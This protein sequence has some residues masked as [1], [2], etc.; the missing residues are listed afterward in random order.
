M[1][2]KKI[3]FFHQNSPQLCTYV[4]SMKG[5]LYRACCV[6]GGRQFCSIC[7]LIS[8]PAL[9]LC[10]LSSVCQG[11][12]SAVVQVAAFTT[13]SSGGLALQGHPHHS[14]WPTAHRPA[15]CLHI[16]LAVVSSLRYF[17]YSSESQELKVLRE[18]GWTLGPCTVSE[19]SRGG[20]PEN[21]LNGSPRT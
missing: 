7:T 3:L 9:H 16:L 17:G 19:P 21:L 2:R 6:W 8:Q 14:L 5:W 1:K 18:V 12:T 15:L 13:Q 11:N 20:F 10:S 4:G